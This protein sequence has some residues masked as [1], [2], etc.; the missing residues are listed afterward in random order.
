[1]IDVL[2]IRDF[3]EAAMREEIISELRLAGGVK[4][5]DS[6]TGELLQ[7]LV[8]PPMDYTKKKPRVSDKDLVSKAAWSSDGKTL[9]VISADGKSVSL[10]G[11]S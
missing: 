9:Y 8:T 2:E 5:F 3:L 4:V 7:T 10:W 11:L 1:M 6:L